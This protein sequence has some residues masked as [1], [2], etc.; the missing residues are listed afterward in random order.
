METHNYQEKEKEEKVKVIVNFETKKHPFIYNINEKVE[1]LMDEFSKKIGLP[2]DSLLFLSKGKR[3]NGEETFSQLK[4]NIYNN[5]KQLIEII[6]LAYRNPNNNNDQSNKIKIILIINSEKEIDLQ[7]T[8]EETFGNIIKKAKIK[9]EININNF[10]FFYKDN[11]LD[12]DKK[13]DDIADEEDKNLNRMIIDAKERRPIKDSTNMVYCNGTYIINKSEAYSSN[14]QLKKGNIIHK[15]N[16]NIDLKNGK[17]IGFIYVKEPVNKANQNNETNQGNNDTNANQLIN[18]EKPEP[19]N[20]ISCFKKY[21]KCII[22]LSVILIL[23]IVGIIILVISKKSDDNEKKNTH[24]S[25]PT[26]RANPN[27]PNDTTEDTVVHDDNKGECEIGEEE[28]CLTCN[29][30]KN[31]CQTCN[32][33]FKLVK[34][35]CKT[36][37]FMKV[38]YFTKQKNDKIEIINDYSDVAYIFIEGKNITPSNINYQFKEEGYQTVYF[39]FEE[40]YYYNSKLFT[41]NKHIKS[42]IFSDFN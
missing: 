3:L 18:T 2:K 6:I 27:E 42:V 7:E 22:I 8:K 21:K 16:S 34:G 28:K 38:V 39:Q 1:T 29:E 10:D 4:D 41:N 26:D 13:F 17:T 15:K 23:I 35:K 12:F 11:K 40:K 30:N 20:G 32:I 9:A 5:D 24:T 33:G 25:S 37:Y 31:E 19:K 36:D 14:K